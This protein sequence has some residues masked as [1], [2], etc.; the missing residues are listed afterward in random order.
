MS[1]PGLRATI[2]MLS[3]GYYGGFGLSLDEVQS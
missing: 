1:T 2:H 3:N